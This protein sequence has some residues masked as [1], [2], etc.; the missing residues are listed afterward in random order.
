MALNAYSE[1]RP[2]NFGFGPLNVIGHHRDPTPKAHPW[3]KP[4]LHT[5]FGIDHP[6]TG[7]TCAR[8]KEK[9]KS[10]ERN[11]QWQTGCSRRPPT[12]TYS[13]MW[14]CMPGGLL[15]IIINLKFRRN[16]FNGFR[17]TRGRISLFPYFQWLIIT[18]FTTVQYN[19]CI[20]PFVHNMKQIH[21]Q[22]ELSEW[23]YC[24]AHGFSSFLAFLLFGVAPLRALRYALH[25]YY[26]CY[27]CT[28]QHHT[29][30]VMI[31]YST[32]QKYT[33][34]AIH[35]RTCHVCVQYYTVH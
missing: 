19:T 24:N 29:N 10:E 9:K 7:T 5:N 22:A 20:K 34:A 35:V 15:E 31:I 32:R 17:D 4:R 28:V 33:S 30:T 6:S 3:P 26:Y 11:L 1:S 8:D 2:P 14:F 12:L 27:L 13:E 16:R 21:V 23:G 18:A 25:L